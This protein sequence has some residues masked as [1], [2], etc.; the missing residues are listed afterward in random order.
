MKHRAPQME[1]PG[2][3]T[4]FNLAGE[5]IHQAA[6]VLKATP[7]PTPNLF[8]PCPQWRPYHRADGTPMRRCADCGQ[9]QSEHEQPTP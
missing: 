3:E 1:M 4:V 2:A 7:D 5:I 6:P 8:G 9:L